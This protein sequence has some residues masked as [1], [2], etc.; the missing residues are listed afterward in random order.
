MEP[1]VPKVLMVLAG[2]SMM[3]HVL[4]TILLRLLVRA[5]EPG[6]DKLFASPVFG[7]L[8]GTPWYL[9][10]KYFLPWVA[11][12]TE[13]GERSR[14]VVALFWAA[15]LAGALFVVAIASSLLSVV[16]EVIHNA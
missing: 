11:A 10:S 13:L 16:Y 6:F 3:A 1:D 12:P 14:P 9:Q 2:F 4:L 15:R 5:G 8:L 7:S